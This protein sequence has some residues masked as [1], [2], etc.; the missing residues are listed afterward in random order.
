MLIDQNS[1]ILGKGLLGLLINAAGGIAAFSIG[2]ALRRIIWGRKIGSGRIGLGRSQKR[3]VVN[4]LLGFALP[5]TAGI[6]LVL[7]GNRLLGSLVLGIAIVDAAFGWASFGASWRTSINFEKG[8]LISGEF[9]LFRRADKVYISDKKLYYRKGEDA[10]SV[11]LSDYQIER[12]RQ[13]DI[14]EI[15]Y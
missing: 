1:L 13:V 10:Y 3:G 14:I 9:Y 12:Y 5:A 2:K 15:E 7:N 6:G 8:I 11:E 4:A